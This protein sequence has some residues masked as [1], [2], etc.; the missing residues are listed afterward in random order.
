VL[1]EMG[2]KRTISKD[3]FDTIGLGNYRKN[4]DFE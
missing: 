4:K 2:V 3:E 1:R